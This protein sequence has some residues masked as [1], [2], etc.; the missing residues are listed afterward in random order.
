MG[1]YDRGSGTHHFGA[2]LSVRTIRF[3]VSPHNGPQSRPYPAL[4]GSNL[5]ADLGC[6]FM[7]CR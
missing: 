5:S 4:P 7:R 6:V 3:N 2:W 1:Y